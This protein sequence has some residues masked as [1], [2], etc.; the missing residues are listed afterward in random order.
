MG[1]VNYKTS[2]II[3]LGLRPYETRDF[4]LDPDFMEDARER[5]EENGCSLFD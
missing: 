2:D 4:E 1:T 5:C 3:T